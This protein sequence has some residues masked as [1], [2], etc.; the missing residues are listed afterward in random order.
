MEFVDPCS[1]GDYH[2][3]IDPNE[4]DALL[5]TPG[6]STM[7]E[8]MGLGNKANRMDPYRRQCQSRS[9]VIENSKEF[10]KLEMLAKV[11]APPPGQVQGPGRSRQPQDQ[12]EPD[13][14]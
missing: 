6:G 2:L 8:Q 7:Y 12:R 5:H 11:Q 14:V 3:T 1:C 9:Q 4:K 10:D 13:A